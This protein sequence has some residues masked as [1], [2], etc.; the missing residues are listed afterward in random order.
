MTRVLQPA[1]EEV[2]AEFEPADGMDETDAAAARAN[3][4]LLTPVQC[5]RATNAGLLRRPATVVA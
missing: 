3:A 4:A 5:R 2:P 1:T